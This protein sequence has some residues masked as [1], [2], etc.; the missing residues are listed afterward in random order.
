MKQK[1]GLSE[2]KRPFY[3]WIALSGVSLVAFVVGGAFVYSYGVFLP[4]MCE[5]FGW[6]RAVVSVG[7][8][9]GM[10][11]FSLPGPLTGVLITRF[12]PRINIVLGSLVAALGMAGMS[13]VQ[14]V[15]HVYLV[16]GIAG[17]GAGG[18]GSLACVTVANNWF[19]RKRSLAIGTFTAAAGLGGFA[20]PAIDAVLIT[21]IGW[22]MSWPVLAVILFVVGSLIA[23]LILIRKSPEEMGQVPDGVPVESFDEAG[24]TISLSGVN[25][26]SQKRQNT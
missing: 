15:W 20:F 11:V 3:G 23:G 13:I 14:E 22:R 16:Y 26:V 12:G 1:V 9:L 10:L 19:A 17:L 18:A 6:S 24:V 7:L 2:T 21:S 4:V 25:T 8:M 5:E